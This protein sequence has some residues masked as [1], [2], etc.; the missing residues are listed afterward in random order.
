MLAYS[1]YYSV[2][3]PRCADLLAS[4]PPPLT[5]FGGPSPHSS[6]RN[7][8]VQS[9]ASHDAHLEALAVQA[10]LVA[11]A[12]AAK[13]VAAQQQQQQ[14]QQPQAQQQ[15]QQPQAQQQQQHQVQGASTSSG[16]AAAEVGPSGEASPS[17]SSRLDDGLAMAIVP[18]VTP[19]STSPVM[20]E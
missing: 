17:V 14:Q 16:G 7:S 19:A 15:Q 1:Y 18:A 2:H 6:D 10:R 12:A 20:P 8:V 13:K 4:L 11:A 5:R 3:P 9:F